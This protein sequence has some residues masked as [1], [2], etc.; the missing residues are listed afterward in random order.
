MPPVARATSCSR[1]ASLCLGGR[2]RC[3][4][5]ADSKVWSATGAILFDD[6]RPKDVGWHQIRG[7]LYA[8]ES[9]VHRFGELLDEQSLRQARHAPQQ[10]V[11]AP[12]RNAMRISLTTRCWPTIAFASS[13]SSRPAASATCSNGTSDSDPV[14]HRL[15]SAMFRVATS[16]EW[17]L[18]RQVLH[19]RYFTAG[20]SRRVLHDRCF[21]AGA[22]RQVLHGGCFTTGAS[23]QV[24]HD[25]CFSACLGT[26]N[27]AIRAAIHASNV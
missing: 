20:A 10:A 21:T 1:S 17:S 18:L 11:T 25:R 19:G 14:S 8:V 13:R 9:Q 22:S 24:L 27:G 23:R 4:S 5:S 6:F 3:A 12:V 2:S 26:T 16:H 15:R 7:E